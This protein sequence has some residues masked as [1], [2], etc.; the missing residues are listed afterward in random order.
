MIESRGRLCLL[1][2]AMDALRVGRRLRVEYLYRDLPVQP[3]I[4]RQIDLAHPTGADLRK[5]AVVA[6]ESADFQFA[7]HGS[8]V[9]DCLQTNTSTALSVART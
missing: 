1:Y 9:F 5:D 8:R 4:G 6:K 3:G 2:K 7:G